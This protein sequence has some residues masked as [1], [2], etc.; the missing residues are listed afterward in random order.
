MKTTTSEQ[1]TTSRKLAALL[2]RNEELE[3][4]VSDLQTS[5]CSYAIENCTLREML[6]MK[7][8]HESR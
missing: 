6:R 7:N 4:V 5:L 8:T 1:M 3:R 2:Q